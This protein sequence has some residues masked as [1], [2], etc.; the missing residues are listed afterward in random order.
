MSL[1][2]LQLNNKTIAYEHL[3]GSSPGILFCSGFRSDMN[4]NKARALSEHCNNRGWACTRFDYRGHGASGTDFADCGIGDW[5]D[6]AVDVLD[7]Q[8]S[9]PQIVIGSSMGLWMTLQMTLQRPDRVAAIV[10]IAG[11]PDFTE[12]LIWQKLDSQTRDLLQKGGTWMRPS[13]YD[14]GEPYPISQLLIESGRTHLVTGSTININCPVRLLHGTADADVPWHCSLKVLEQL[15]SSDATLTLI[16]DADHRLSA[17]VE[18]EMILST[19]DRLH[20]QLTA[21]DNSRPAM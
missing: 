21:A 1:A 3:P 19:V 17:P 5:I 10:G 13:R 12:E 4:G 9:G 2:T 11:A 14:D 15:S 20:E 8:T 18:I 16:K 6:D 7:H